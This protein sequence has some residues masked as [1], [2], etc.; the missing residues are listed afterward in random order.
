MRNAIWPA[1]RALRCPARPRM[2]RYAAVAMVVVCMTL[3][4]GCTSGL[5]AAN[6]LVQ[7]AKSGNDKAVFAVF[8]PEA[9]N[10][11]LYGEKGAATALLLAYPRLG[12]M[13]AQAGAGGSEVLADP[14]DPDARLVFTR[15]GLGWTVT[16]ATNDHS[17]TTTETYDTTYITLPTPH[18]PS[19]T[20]L[21]LAGRPGQ[22]NVRVHV[23]EVNG[24]VTSRTVEPWQNIVVTPSPGQ[25]WEGRGQRS[26]ASISNMKV[27]VVVNKASASVA[28][29]MPTVPGSK[30]RVAV[31]MKFNH[32]PAGSTIRVVLLGPSDTVVTGGSDTLKGGFVS[33]QGYSIW[34]APDPKWGPP[35]KWVAVV[36]INGKPAAWK[37]FT[38]K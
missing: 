9:G 11:L 20:T 36:E 31:S 15:S 16:T 32:P 26:K 29:D 7:D 27:G 33:W 35:G 2:R 4:T 17:D 13:K 28:K 22:R 24:V 19:G 25:T 10:G 38:V 34:N 37:V 30:R 18:L 1:R 8:S 3:L 23:V 21:R 12:L 5:S 14:G 6:K